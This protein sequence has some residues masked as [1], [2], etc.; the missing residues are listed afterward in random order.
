MMLKTTIALAALVLT[1]GC[2]GTVSSVTRESAKDPAGTYDGSYLAKVN[3]RGGRQRMDH[4]WRSDCRAQQFAQTL[5]IRNSQVSWYW[6]SD[7][8]VKGFINSA[9][10]FRL[11][12]KL[13]G[14]IKGR[15]QMM[16]DGGVTAILQGQLDEDTMKG[17][18][19]YGVAQFNNH[20]C[21][22]PVTFVKQT[23]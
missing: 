10:E 19:V 12:N 18:F 15:G 11:E 3:S 6:Q 23:S 8:A 2:A 21:S 22:Y 16:S 7:V 13:D 1:S 5:T 20:G 17:M 9:G 4:Q 14:E